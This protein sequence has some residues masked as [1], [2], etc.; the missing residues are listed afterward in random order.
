MSVFVCVFMYVCVCVCVCLCR[1]VGH[2]EGL[3]SGG[4]GAQQV[5][6]LGCH[7]SG[8]WPLVHLLGGDVVG[9]ESVTVLQGCCLRVATNQEGWVGVGVARSWG[10][11]TGQVVGSSSCAGGRKGEKG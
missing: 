3:V 10:Q 5:W 11:V 6:P 2:G 9:E 8:G 4:E 7:G 1:R